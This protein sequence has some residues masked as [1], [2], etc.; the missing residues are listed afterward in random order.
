MD[1]SSTGALTEYKPQRA[2]G[3]LNMPGHI[4]V[5]L[6]NPVTL[7]IAVHYD[8]CRLRWDILPLL[9]LLVLAPGGTTPSITMNIVGGHHT[10]YFDGGAAGQTTTVSTGTTHLGI[11]S[12]TTV[13]IMGGHHT[14]Y[15]GGGGATV[16]I[17]TSTVANEL[18]DN[19]NHKRR[20]R[21]RPNKAARRPRLAAEQTNSQDATPPAV[22]T[23]DTDEDMI[24]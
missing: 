18:R 12:S 11:T 10:W 23:E 5:A 13:N 21:K 24:Q 2:D 4:H 20:R 19:P 17:E 8:L 1:S 9:L 22:K 3:M 7:Q 6:I 15:F 16:A 14:W